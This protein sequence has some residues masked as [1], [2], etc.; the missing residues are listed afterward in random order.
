MIKKI[1]GY[2][3]LSL[4]S[5]FFFFAV[6]HTSANAEASPIAP[7]LAQI[8]QAPSPSPTVTTIPQQQIYPPITKTTTT[9][10]PPLKTKTTS[11]PTKTPTKT[12]TPTSTPT[13]TP[14]PSST[15]TPT[16]TA[17]LTPTPTDTPTEIPTPTVAAATQP[18]DTDLENWFTKYADDYHI[19]RELLRHIAQCESGF[20][21]NSNNNGLYLGMY[22]FSRGTW[23]S[24]RSAMGL[25]TNPDLRT[26]AEEAI[27]TAA[28]KISQGGAGA[29]PNCN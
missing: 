1:A 18:T 26:N 7:L 4:S 20:N 22:Q 15:D 23:I 29:W 9:P 28:F 11:S 3:L 21:T 10:K 14:T 24:A 16:P 5:F 17:T 27:K 2:S 12:S 25:D 13:N 19:D 8:S 6:F